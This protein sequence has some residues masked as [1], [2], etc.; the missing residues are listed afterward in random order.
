MIL[1]WKNSIFT[2]SHLNLQ[3]GELLFPKGQNYISLNF[4]PKSQSV[5][6]FNF[7]TLMLTS[8]VKGMDFRKSLTRPSFFLYFREI[9]NKQSHWPGGQSAPKLYNL[10]NLCPCARPAHVGKCWPG[11][12]SPKLWKSDGSVK[13]YNSVSVRYP[14][15]KSKKKMQRVSA[16][17]WNQTQVTWIPATHLSH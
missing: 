7:S 12:S 6:L 14:L 10:Y 5:N 4:S 15:T 2:W 9:R 13:I 16:P 1:R 11:S 17:C 8:A 3:N